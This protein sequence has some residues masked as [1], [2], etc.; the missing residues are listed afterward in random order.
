MSPRR[1]M[2]IIGRRLVNLAFGEWQ[3]WMA[4]IGIIAAVV[5][6]LPLAETLQQQITYSGTILQVLG[7][8]TVAWGLQESR[9]LFNHPGILTK[10][11]KVF[12]KPQG[13]TV[14]VEAALSVLDA[15]PLTATVGLP[16][17]PTNE[18]RLAALE[19]RLDHT[20]T[21]I[22]ENE[23]KWEGEV[24][25]LKERLESEETARKAELASIQKQI[26]TA[27]IGGLRLEQTGLVWLAFG[28]V[29][30][31]APE[32]IAWITRPAWVLL[33]WR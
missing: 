6:A 26:E 3:F 15:S 21:S 23:K 18:Q 25:N 19:R 29:M 17:T 20:E 27:V 2:R 11:A 7:L 32:F 24:T 4:G 12:A 9:R 5:V 16:G 31:T 13:V 8:G 1:R 22:R 30:G 10:L 33:G 14:H 28:V